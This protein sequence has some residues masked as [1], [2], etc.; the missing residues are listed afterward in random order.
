MQGPKYG[1]D[2][3]YICGFVVHSVGCVRM[4]VRRRGNTMIIIHES[5]QYEL[6][7]GPHARKGKISSICNSV[8]T[9]D[10]GVFVMR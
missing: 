3:I 10:S 7:S 8:S 5:Q 9:I 4:H 1:I 2:L 6:R